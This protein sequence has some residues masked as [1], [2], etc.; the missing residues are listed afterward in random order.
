MRDTVELTI[1]ASQAKVA[2]LFDDPLTFPRWMKEL[3]RV[4]P[5][6]GSGQGT[7]YRM[8]PK[9]GSQEF[10]VHR[11]ARDLPNWSQLTLNGS[12]VSVEV[13]GTFVKI[14]S[15]STR[16]VSEEVF[17]FQG[18]TGKIMGLL[19][20]RGIQEAHR[21]HME[22]FKRFAEDGAVPARKSG[23]RKNR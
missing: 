18:L 8:V 7:S 11:V 3:E 19:G 5:M 20:R 4:E 16:L 1:H 6:R 12:G 14:S 9:P 15:G 13:K 10:L 21:K 2:V 22:S 23:A 17:T